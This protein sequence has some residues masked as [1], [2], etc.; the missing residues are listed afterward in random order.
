MYEVE[1]ESFVM[2]L[3]KVLDPDCEVDMQSLWS[4]WLQ[5][6]MRSFSQTAISLSYVGS[7]I[8]T[9]SSIPS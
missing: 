2:L 9:S 1:T 3:T 4:P 5:L 7:L 8:Y 6:L